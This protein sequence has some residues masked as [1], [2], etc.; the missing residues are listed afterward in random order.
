MDYPIGVDV[1]DPLD[2]LAKHVEI[3]VS[4]HFPGREVEV[5][6]QWLS[7]VMHLDQFKRI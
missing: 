4:V 2:H 3:Q 5:V 1:F 6:P 7:G